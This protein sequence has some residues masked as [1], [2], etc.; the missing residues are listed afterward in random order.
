MPSQII[1]QSWSGKDGAYDE[2]TYPLDG[3]L[4]RSA[5]QNLSPSN[6]AEE[7]NAYV[8]TVSAFDDENKDLSRGSFTTMAHAS[9]NGSVE[10][11]D[12]IS[13]VNEASV[14]LKN[15]LRDNQTQWGPTCAEEGSPRAL[16][17]AEK[18]TFKDLVESNPDRYGDIGLSSIDH[19]IMLQLMLYDEE[20]SVFSHDENNRKLVAEMPLVRDDDDTHEP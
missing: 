7:K 4:E 20:S 8:W 1:S 16:V 3:I 12:Y 5:V 11:D 14:Y 13:R 18:S 9:T 10:N 2:D 15:H 17:E 6:S 19:D